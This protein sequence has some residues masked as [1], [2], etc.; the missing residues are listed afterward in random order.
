MVITTTSQWVRENVHALV[1]ANDDFPVGID[2]NALRETEIFVDFGHEK[3]SNGENLHTI[4]AG[5]A[6]ED[7]TTCILC[8]AHWI[9]EV[10]AS[11]TFV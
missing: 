9:Q 10:T 1:V 4:V 5:V 11:E 6:H 2:A 7:I 3:T 8:E